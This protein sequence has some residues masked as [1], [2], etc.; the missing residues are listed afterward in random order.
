MITFKLPADELQLAV[1]ALVPRLIRF[2]IAFFY[3]PGTIQINDKE[4]P[5]FKAATEGMGFN[6][7]EVS[8]DTGRA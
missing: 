8:R 7:K 3:K 6:F 2:R 4:L 1:H 5:L